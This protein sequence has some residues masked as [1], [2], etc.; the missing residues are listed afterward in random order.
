[1]QDNTVSLATHSGKIR[2][3]LGN[4]VKV[5]KKHSKGFSKFARDSEAVKTVFDGID[6]GNFSS[7]I[8]SVIAGLKSL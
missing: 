3:Q 4:P 5:C 1:V 2:S 8:Q 7:K 6:G